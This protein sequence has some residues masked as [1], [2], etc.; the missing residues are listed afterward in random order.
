MSDLLQLFSVLAGKNQ[1]PT[2][3][4]VRKVL[5]ATIFTAMLG[6]LVNTLY[7][8]STYMGLWFAVFSFCSGWNFWGLAK[9]VDRTIPIGWGRGSGVHTFLMAQA[10]LFLTGFLVYVTLVWWNAPVAAILSGLSVSLF[11][12]IVCGLLGTVSAKS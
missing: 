3:V 9:L 4:L 6:L 2:A 7:P 11:W 8:S 12:A 1:S 10:R 5:L